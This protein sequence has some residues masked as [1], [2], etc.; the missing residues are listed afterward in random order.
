MF[1]KC[2]YIKTCE[3]ATIFVCTPFPRPFLPQ[4][5]RPTLQG[6]PYLG[7]HPTTASPPKARPASAIAQP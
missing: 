4:F 7:T 6:T 2:T 5:W 1:T 3:E